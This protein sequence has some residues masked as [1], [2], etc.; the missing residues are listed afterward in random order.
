[1]D[2]IAKWKA[3]ADKNNDRDKKTKTANTASH[4]AERNRP[5]SLHINYQ[6]TKQ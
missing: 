3:K 6:N 4:L 1:M 5:V 2:H